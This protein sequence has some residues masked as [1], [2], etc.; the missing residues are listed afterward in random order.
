VIASQALLPDLLSDFRRNL[1]AFFAVE[2]GDK[3][4]ARRPRLGLTLVVPGEPEAIL[5]I[6]PDWCRWRK[7]LD[8]ETLAVDLLVNRPV[9]EDIFQRTSHRPM[10]LGIILTPD[11]ARI[12]RRSLRYGDEGQERIA[13]VVADF[14]ANPI[15]SPSR[16]YDRCCLCR[17]KLTDG[18]SMLRGYGPE[19]SKKIR[20]LLGFLTGETDG[21]GD[22]AAPT[23]DFDSTLS[24]SDE[25]DDEDHEGGGFGIEPDR[26]DEMIVLPDSGSGAEVNSSPVVLEAEP[27]VEEQD[28]LDQY[29]DPEAG[30]WWVKSHH[31]Q[32]C[33]KLPW[34]RDRL[35][36]PASA[37]W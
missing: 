4:L 11:G 33:V 5:E 6:R 28:P 32:V 23:W 7:K 17:C 21:I 15:A 29:F 35:T 30:V 18:T 36:S 3:A 34:T 16:S 8:T 1:S 25:P 31:G 27:E 24:V 10:E 13:E 14:Q 22:A 9:R 20:T 19:C 2:A 37:S 26:G 12:N